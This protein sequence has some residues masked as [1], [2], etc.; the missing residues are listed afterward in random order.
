MKKSDSAHVVYIITKLE[1][2]GAQKVCLSLFDG[3]QQQSPSSCSLISGSSG[4]LVDTIQAFE[5]VYFI[6]SMQREV[7]WSLKK[8]V[9]EIKTFF[10]IIKILRTIKKKFSQVIVHTHSTKAGIIGRW[11]ALCAGI[12]IRIHTIHGYGFHEHQSRITWL[13]IYFLEYVTSLITTHF[14]CVSEQDQQTGIRLF[15]KFSLKNSLIRAAID[16]KKFFPAQPTYTSPNDEQDIIIGTVSCFKPQKNLFDL[17]KAFDYVYHHIPAGLQKRIRLQIIGDGFLRSE[18]EAWI[19]QHQLSTHIDLLGWQNN[20]ANWMQTWKVFA[21]SSLW[22]GLPC[23]IVEA[24]LCKLPV[25]AYHVGGIGE[26]IKDGQNGFLIQ[27]K[28][29]KL[30]AQKIL[31]ALYLQERSAS[32][33]HQDDALESFQNASMISHH[34]KLYDNFVAHHESIS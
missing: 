17:L 28:D 1:L 13:A 32:I 18:L 19:V 25:V 15:P 7:G 12:P 20:V 6:D 29:W 14:V 30:L 2:G 26:I 27:P 4:T 33:Y 8:I 22:E 31:E 9:Q 21:L 16:D 11:A 5:S 34:I 10:S 24:R 3:L 23:A